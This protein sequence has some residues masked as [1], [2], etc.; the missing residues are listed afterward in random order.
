M[1]TENISDLLHVLNEDLARGGLTHDR[2]RIESKEP[3]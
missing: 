1:N 3:M 2:F